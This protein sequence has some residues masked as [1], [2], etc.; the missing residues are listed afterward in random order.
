MQVLTSYAT[1]EWYTPPEYVQ[2]AR[3]VLGDIDLDPAS[4]A[5][6]QSWIRA[7]QFYTE[8]EDGLTRPWYGRV[9]LN[10]PYGK[11]RNKSNMDVWASKLEA[12]Y[13]A[14]RVTAA[15]LLINSTHG[16]AWYERLWTR[17][18]VCCARERIRFID[19]EGRQAGEAKRGQTFLY[20][21]TD[22]AA[23]ARVFSAIGRVILPL[24]AGRDSTFA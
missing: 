3:E 20:M 11:T 6:P 4:A 7:G 13:G 19:A 21:G 16:Y 15:V 2:L 5:L 8:R 12:E 23:F 18:P 9:W 17:Y 14:G 24:E 22:L 1:G 10:P